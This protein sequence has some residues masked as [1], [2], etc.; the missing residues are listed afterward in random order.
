M[1]FYSL[2]LIFTYFFSHFYCASNEVHKR[3]LSPFT[4]HKR[5]FKENKWEQTGN[6]FHIT[7]SFVC[8]QHTNAI[9]FKFTKKNHFQ[10]VAISRAVM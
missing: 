7:G 9:L 8:D 3:W 2:L 1:F 10:I 6:E 5:N 4:L